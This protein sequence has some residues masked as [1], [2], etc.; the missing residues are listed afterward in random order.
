M[1]DG[2]KEIVGGGLN[3]KEIPDLDQSENTA[4]SS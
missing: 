4:R 1:P 2:T 3:D